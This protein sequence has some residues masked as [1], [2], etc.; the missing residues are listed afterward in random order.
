MSDD[1]LAKLYGDIISYDI[2]DDEAL[3]R[4][5]SV[6]ED[7]SYDLDFKYYL[8]DILLHVYI[9]GYYRYDKD[10]NHLENVYVQN[11]ILLVEILPNSGMYENAIIA[12]LKGDLDKCI[13]YLQEDVEENWINKNA[14]FTEVD[15]LDFII[16]PFKNATKD[17]WLSIKSILLE[18]EAEPSVLALCDAMYVYYYSQNNDTIINAFTKALQINPNSMIAKELLGYIYYSIG[19]WKN[20]LAY[21]EQLNV[22]SIF[23][24]ADF[25]FFM[26]WAYGKIKDRT[27]EILYYRKC[28]GKDE[29]YPNALNNLGYA[30]YTNKQYYEAI[31]V[32]T[33]CIDEERDL[34]YSIRNYVKALLKLG[35]NKDAKKFVRNSKH[36]FPKDI[37]DKV[38]AASNVNTRLKRTEFENDLLY[39][40]EPEDELSEDDIA[41]LDD[42]PILEERV[43]DDEE[44]VLQNF[45]LDETTNVHIAEPQINIGEK[46]F[47][48]S[49]EKLLEDELTTRLDSWNDIFGVPLKIY[50]R[51]GEYGRQYIIPEGRLDLLAEDKEGNLYIIELKKDEGYDDAYN[52]IVSYLDWFE[53]NKIEK[54]EN[55]YGIICLN[56]PSEDLVQR[57]RQDKRVSLFEY[58]ISYTEIC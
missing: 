11:F 55:V 19:M 4:I 3:K 54:G 48:F 21:F 5:R 53:Q 38:N 30:Y 20:A 40:R 23:Y 16:N 42:E 32:F 14:T 33:K 44:L 35:R 1:E 22:T 13:D 24:D 10:T 36:R 31:E 51:R 9:N 47:Q 25:Y 50:R 43:L 12:F 2:T 18:A 57:V 29:L 28:L 56:N 41:L 52:Q 39:Y 6:I 15:L 37:V 8:C 34:P 7:D 17:F 27:N 58:H 46:K 49:N 26:A 45:E